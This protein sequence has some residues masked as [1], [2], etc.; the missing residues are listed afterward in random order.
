V[1]ELQLTYSPYSLKLKQPF[2]TS[3]SVISERN[4][5]I[6]RIKNQNGLE[7]IGDAC[8]FPEFGSES[9]QQAE[10][11]LANLNMRIKINLKNVNESIKTN[12]KNLERTPALR[13]GIEQAVLNLLCK[14]KKISLNS[15]LNIKLKN[16]IDVNAAIGF[17]SVENTIGKASEFISRGYNTLKIKCGRDDFDQEMEC[18]RSLREKFRQKINLRIDVNGNWNLNQ[19]IHKLKEMESLQLEYAEQPVEKMQVMIELK[20]NCKIPVAADESV[21]SKSEA[22]NIIKHN[23]ADILILKPMMIGG[24]L[25]TIE[26][27]DLAQQNNI[28]CVVTSSFES[29]VGRSNAAI[30][31]A[32]SKTKFAHGL[33]VNTFFEKDLIEDPFP[34]QYGK[35]KLN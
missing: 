4:G 14:E 11:V 6:I 17:D 18:L 30:A 22:E 16:E 9:L 31:A 13:H 15:L 8:P 27:I 28:D 10:E 34:V 35:I 24:L 25:P 3:N 26:I 23:A 29:A 21:R 19:A 2:T 32:Y 33:S 5:F 20:K 1:N 12:L 7:G